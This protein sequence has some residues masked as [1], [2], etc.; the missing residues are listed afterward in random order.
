MALTNWMTAFERAQASDL[1]SDLERAYEAALLIQGFE[2]E[3]YNDRPVRPELELGIPRQTQAQILRRFK[4]VVYFPP[5]RAEE[6]LRLWR[7]G[8]SSCTQVTADLERIARD[9]ELTGSAIINVTRKVSLAA[10]ARGGKDTGPEESAA[11]AAAGSGESPIS[12]GDIEEAIRSERG[13][14]G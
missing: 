8:F 13:K 9:H 1:T 6:H 4:A 3:Y 12:H 14:N 11:E 10:I 7:E 2:L 5:P